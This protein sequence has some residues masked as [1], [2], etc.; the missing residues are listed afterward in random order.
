M[1]SN[2]FENNEDVLM[3]SN[4]QIKKEIQAIRQPSVFEDF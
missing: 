3:F 4:P 2:I 1:N